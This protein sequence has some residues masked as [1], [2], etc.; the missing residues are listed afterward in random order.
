[1]QITAFYIWGMLD[2]LNTNFN[3]KAKPSE[4]K[5]G[6]FGRENSTFLIKFLI[7]KY[8]ELP[9]IYIIKYAS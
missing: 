1:M 2:S 8:I 7:F 3:S 4:Q 6:H 9:V 5:N